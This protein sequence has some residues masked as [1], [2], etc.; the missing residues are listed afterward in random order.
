MK[1]KK[2]RFK[3]YKKLKVWIVSGEKNYTTHETKEEAIKR[4][5]IL[6]E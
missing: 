5:K 1:T 4:R 3:V 6:E 2:H